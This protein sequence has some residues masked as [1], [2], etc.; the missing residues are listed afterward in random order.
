MSRDQIEQIDILTWLFQKHPD[1]QLKT[2]KAFQLF[3]EETEKETSYSNF[4]SVLSKLRSKTPEFLDSDAGYGKIKLGEKGRKKADFKLNPENHSGLD[5]DETSGFYSW[6]VEDVS[7]FLLEKKDAEIDKAIT[8]GQIFELP[9]SELEE[10]NVE[11]IDSGLQNKPQEFITGVQEAFKDVK[12]SSEATP[13]RLRFDTDDY[14]KGL[15]E[16]KKSEN[17]GSLVQTEGMIR[18]CEEISSEVVGT[19]SECVQCG[20]RYEKEITDGEVKTPY[21]CECG[22]KQFE[23]LERQFDDFIQFEISSN[24]VQNQVLECRVNEDYLFD[25]YQDK[26]RTGRRVRIAGFIEKKKISKRSKKMKT[27]FNV[28]DYELVDKKAEFGEIDEDVKETVREKVEKSDNPHRDFSLSIAPN[29]ECMELPKK[30]I[31]AALIGSTPFESQNEYGKI[32][33]C[34]YSNPGMGKSGLMEPVNQLF[35]NV[36]SADNNSTGVGLTGTVTQTEDNRWRVTAGT[37]V[38]ADKGV[39][40]IDEFDKISGEDLGSLNSAMSN[41]YIKINKAARAKMPARA[42]IIVG[43]NFDK[44]LTK[45]DE[46]REH[47]PDKAIGFSDRFALMSAITEQDTEKVSGAIFDKY[48]EGSRNKDVFFTEKELIAYRGIAQSYNPTISDEARDKLKEFV[49]AELD[50]A[51]SKDNVEFQGES[52]RFIENLAELTM[53]FARSRFSSKTTK[54]DAQR[55]YDLFRKCR[56]TLGVGEGEPGPKGW[57]R[58]KVSEIREEIDQLSNDDSGADKQEVIENVEV[59]ENQAEETIEDLK[60]KGEIF[61]PTQGEVKLL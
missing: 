54:K 17:I 20:S 41:G 61:E 26:L 32:H 39:L 28:F 33:V 50:V 16:V 25:D 36:H 38:F 57:R 11:L 35:S 53:M 29:I 55:A 10:F 6:V 1:E 27:V 24:D 58:D 31:G 59:S 44:Q 8:R 30:Q 52:N 23:V 14:L 51:E 21:K 22:S 48:S 37:M 60:G 47:L 40:M 19:V 56:Q 34:F 2:K 42:S 45:F 49:N 5:Q 46:V 43:G 3:C 4:N 9:L 15:G 7:H 12:E 18:V 13:L